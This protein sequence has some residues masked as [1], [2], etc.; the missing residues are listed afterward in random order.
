MAFLGKVLAGVVHGVPSPPG[1]GDIRPVAN[2][3]AIKATI[4]SL[5]HLR[6]FLE[7]ELVGWHADFEKT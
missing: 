3:K 5:P 7:F 6:K 4:R 2:G 1:R